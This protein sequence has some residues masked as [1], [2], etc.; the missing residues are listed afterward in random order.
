M[1]ENPSS[2][3]LSPSGFDVAEH[4]YVGIITSHLL[5]ARHLIE[6]IQV[7]ANMFPLVVS[8]WAKAANIFPAHARVVMLIDL[9]GM[10]VPSSGY[11][12]TLTAQIPGCGFLA[13]DR[14]RKDIDVALLLRIGFAGFLTHDEALCL[15]GPAIHAVA[16]GSV[17]ASPSVMRLYM[18]ATSRHAKVYEMGAATLT[19][20]ENQ[21]LD[22]LR[23]R[24]SNRELASFLQISESTVKFHVSN[25]LMKLNATGRRDL[26]DQDRSSR[27]VPW[28]CIE[29]GPKPVAKE[30]RLFRRNAFKSQELNGN[31][32]K[33][34]TQGKKTRS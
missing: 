32:L 27:Q 33:A 5:A 21:V 20:R 25:V 6:L 13:L 22:L 19:L 4:L 15:L 3:G 31:G 29:L 14:P 26:T 9:W 8:D 7:N 23:M 12:D 11:L 28:S 1:F 30:P 18:H 34:V 10:P 2:T 17:W 24:Y 16:E